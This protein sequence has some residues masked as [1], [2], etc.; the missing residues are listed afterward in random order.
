MAIMEIPSALAEKIRLKTEILP[1][2]W[3]F[4]SKG[5]LVINDEAEIATYGSISYDNKIY[6]LGP[7][8]AMKDWYFTF[9][10]KSFIGRCIFPDNNDPLLFVLTAFYKNYHCNFGIT[11]PS[12]EHTVALFTNLVLSTF[13]PILMPTGS[14]P[15]LDDSRKV[16][17][18]WKPHPSPP[19]PISSSGRPGKTY[20]SVPLH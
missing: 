20:I 3:R 14:A 13:G 6:E 1:D 16:R 9:E 18:E 8:I 5:I 19:Q 11:L 10:R 4:K 15:L 2:S 17:I 7:A 12:N